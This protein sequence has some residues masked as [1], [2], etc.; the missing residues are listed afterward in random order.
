MAVLL[1]LAVDRE[2]ES[3]LVG[4][5]IAVLVASQ[6]PQGVQVSA[7][8]LLPIDLD[9][10]A[11]RPVQNSHCEGRIQQ[12]DPSPLPWIPVWLVCQ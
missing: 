9:V 10:P 1:H 5:G 11:A 4:I 6:G 8:L 12:H 7:D 3:Q 2:P